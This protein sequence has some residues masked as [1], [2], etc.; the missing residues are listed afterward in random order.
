MKSVIVLS[1]S[2]WGVFIF[3]RSC[4]TLLSPVICFVIVLPF[5]AAVRSHSAWI[6]SW[7]CS[8]DPA[9][10]LVQLLCGN[11]RLLEDGEVVALL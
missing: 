10:A 9:E 8:A 6:S 2:A 3:L 4:S 1:V 11:S 5:R 7:L